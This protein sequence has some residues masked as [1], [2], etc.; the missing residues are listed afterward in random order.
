[1]PKG[2]VLPSGTATIG[3]RLKSDRPDPDSQLIVRIKDGND[4]YS[5]YSLG[6]LGLVDFLGNIQ[7]SD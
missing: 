1:M 7:S 5:S 4:R 6:R 3:K 2:I